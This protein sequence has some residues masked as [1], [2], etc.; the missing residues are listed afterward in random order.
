MSVLHNHVPIKKIRVAQQSLSISSGGQMGFTSTTTKLVQRRHF[1][2]RIAAP[3]IPAE[4]TYLQGQRRG[5]KASFADQSGRDVLIGIA[6]GNGKASTDDFFKHQR[7]MV[8]R[9][10]GAGVHDTP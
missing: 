9:N 3:M 8:F 4:D 10:L 5:K 1:G 7:G 6:T 2:N